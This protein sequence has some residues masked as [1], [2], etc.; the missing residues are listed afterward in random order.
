MKGAVDSLQM[1]FEPLIS[2]LCFA[3]SNVSGYDQGYEEWGVMNEGG[4]GGSKKEMTLRNIFDIALTAIAYLSFGLFVLQVIMCITL[5]TPTI[6]FPLHRTR[7]EI[8]SIILQTKTHAGMTMMPMTMDT[9]GMEELDGAAEMTEVRRKKRSTSSSILSEVNVSDHYAPRFG[10]IHFSNLTHNQ[11]NE[12][13]RRVL[14]SIDAGIVAEIDN[15]K[16][17][18]KVLCENNKYARSRKDNQKIWMPIW[19]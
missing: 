14:R 3:K 6:F 1:S 11:I 5:V 7:K 13:S 17:L 18:Q 8:F 4:G 2:F 9:D 19:G 10:F 15:G 12:L 16:C